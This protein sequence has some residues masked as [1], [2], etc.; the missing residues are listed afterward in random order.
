MVDKI[1]VPTTRPSGDD[2]QWKREVME[3]LRQLTAQV[4]SLQSQLGK[5]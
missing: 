1:P 2:Q 5:R 3:T 4:F